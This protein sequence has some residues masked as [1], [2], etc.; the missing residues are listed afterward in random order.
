MSLVNVC[1]NKHT[2]GIAPI[3]KCTHSA[4]QEITVIKWNINEIDNGIV[5]LCYVYF[6]I[7]FFQ[8]QQA[9]ILSIL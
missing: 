9:N 8:V 4:P 2:M 3:F 5:Y 6:G 1:S 7:F